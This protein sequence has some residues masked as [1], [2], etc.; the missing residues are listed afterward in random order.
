M[1]YIAHLIYKPTKAK[2]V[3]WTLQ[4]IIIYTMVTIYINNKNI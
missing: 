3:V 2:L 1:R 4:N